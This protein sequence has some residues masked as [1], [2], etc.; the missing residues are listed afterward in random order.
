MTT[1]TTII[2]ENV[3]IETGDIVVNFDENPTPFN[4]S[5][6]VNMNDL[7]MGKKSNLVWIADQRIAY[8]QKNCFKPDF[9]IEKW[10]SWLVV[11][12]SKPITYNDVVSSMKKH[13]HY[14]QLE[15]A[16]DHSFLEV[17]VPYKDIPNAYIAEFGS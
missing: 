7:F 16:D 9:N 17:F 8:Q 1:K 11:K 14:K 15:G 6:E 5:L 4:N 10:T 3:K 13:F 2:N 12:N